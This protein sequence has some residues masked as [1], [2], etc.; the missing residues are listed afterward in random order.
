MKNP[1][2]TRR[3][4][5][6]T[7]ALAAAALATGACHTTAAA[8][9][10]WPI[11]CFNRPWMQKFGSKMQPLD[12]LQPANWGFDVALKGVKEAGYNTIGL[13]SSLPGE[14]F[15][16][17][18]AT[19][20]YL[21]EL[22]S[23]IAASGLRSE[24]GAIR[25]KA[26]LPLAAAIEDTRR[27]IDRAKFLDLK[28]LLTFGVDKKE[29]YQKYYQMMADAADYAQETGIKV[30]M[31]PHGGASGAAREIKQCLNAVKRPNFKIWYDA[32]NII[33][34]GGK[35]PVEELKPIAQYV[36]GFCAKDC[37]GKGGDVMVPFGQ[38]KVD[39]AGVFKVLKAAGFNGPIY[40]ESASGQTFAEVT[41]SA[42]ANR[43]F[44]EKVF[45]A[46]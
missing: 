3:S 23:R 17:S 18:D 45:A 25:V 6:Q 1:L 33:Y 26:D 24:M 39:F 31:K 36:T 7:T 21:T 13:L 43:L 44:L 46:V 35:D 10:S 27:Q 11:G 19:E 9:S 29:Y 30:V 8:G 34:Y 37:P 14:F 28:W 22:K 15:I 42:R 38:G 41:E 20:E 5:L 40:V 4:F 2:L 16:G 12:A 32:G